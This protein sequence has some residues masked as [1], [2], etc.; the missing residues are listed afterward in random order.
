MAFKRPTTT[1]TPDE[2]FDEWVHKLKHAELL[3]LL[4]IVRRTFGFRD[5]YGEIKDGDT[6]SLRQFHEGIVTR[7]GKRLDH[8]CGVRS[9]TSL[10]AAL[11]RLEELGLIRVRRTES[12]EKGNETTWF[13]LAFVGNDAGVNVPPKDPTPPDATDK[14]RSGTSDEDPFVAPDRE[15]VGGECE[16]SSPPIRGSYQGGYA[17]RTGGSTQIVPGGVRKTHPQQTAETTNRPKQ[18]TAISKREGR[19][20]RGNPPLDSTDSTALA[21]NLSL[22][23]TTEPDALSIAA[24][25]AHLATE[26]GDDAPQASRTRVSN[27]RRGSGL[28]DT[29]LLALLDE[30]AAITRS[31]AA[32]ITKRGRSGA[33]IRMPYLLATLRTLID[34][35]DTRATPVLVAREDVSALPT[36]WPADVPD[37]DDSP[38]ATEA[39][40]VWQAV[41]TEVRQ[42]VTPENYAAWFASTQA[43]ALDAD[44]LSVGVS[45]SFQQQWLEYKLRGCVERALE[46]TGHGGVRITYDIALSG[47]AASLDDRA[48]DQTELSPSDAGRAHCPVATPP[49]GPAAL[50]LARPTTVPITSPTMT[51]LA[52]APPVPVSAM[53]PCP[54]C[55]PAPCRCHLADQLRRVVT[56][57]AALTPVRTS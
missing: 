17:D 45:T 25:V 8:G 31:Q 15:A 11:K 24:A 46:R 49:E 6:I 34:A 4:Y 43:V 52:P 40:A 16:L 53:A 33:V 38:V 27:M 7:A 18:Q 37:I 26:F 57:R 2:I 3:A 13:A 1:P 12:A 5:R 55:R 29:A 21:G 28:D 23:V 44:V 56:A 30:A 20:G 47:Q 48:A 19:S 32:A 10:S 35:S 54:C 22:M 41:L 42:D 39:A 50:S 14:M 36:P 51:S 9:K